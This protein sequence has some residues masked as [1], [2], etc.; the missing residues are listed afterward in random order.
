MKKILPIVYVLLFVFALSCKKESS[1]SQTSETNTKNTILID[2]STFVYK[3]TITVKNSTKDGKLS[4]NEAT[5]SKIIVTITYA[6]SNK[7]TITVHIDKNPGNSIVS[8]FL[9]GPNTSENIGNGVPDYDTSPRSGTFTLTTPGNYYVEGDWQDE[10][11]HGDLTYRFPFT[12]YAPPQPPAGMIG[13][14]RYFNPVNG[15]HIVTSNW[16]ELASTSLNFNFEKVLGYAYPDASSA[17]GLKPI[18]RY[19]NSASGSHYTTDQYGTFTGFVYEKILGYAGI[20]QSAGMSKALTKW[21]LGSI[22]NRIID[23]HFVCVPPEV[24]LG[25]VYT[26][27]KIDFIFGYVQ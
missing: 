8:Y 22:D 10:T 12:I 6:G 19:Y 4:V 26:Q 20:N 27:D 13:F 21:Y 3:D 9:E 17:A 25:T 2:K 11:L 24:P 7:Y 23:D 14:Y 1:P 18:Y 5:P 15:Q 16:E